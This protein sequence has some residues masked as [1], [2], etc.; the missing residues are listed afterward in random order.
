MS[1]GGKVRCTRCGTQN[2]EFHRFCGM[3]GSSL[4]SPPDAPSAPTEVADAGAF[5][6]ATAP[7]SSSNL[8]GAEAGVS[9]LS[10]TDAHRRRGE[11]DE[12]GSAGS[13]SAGSER[14]ESVASESTG[15]A[16]IGSA[17][18]GS[19]SA[20]SGVSAP[21]VSGPSFLGLDKGGFTASAYRDESSDSGMGSS[22]MGGGEVR[23]SRERYGSNLDY[24]L[25]DE[26]E[27]QRAWGKLMSVVVAL[28]LLGGFGYLRWKQGG[29][30]WLTKDKEK[31]RT[32]VSAADSKPPAGDSTFTTAPANDAASPT[33][34]PG[35]PTADP[36]ASAP[37][38]SVPSADAADTAVAP[39]TAAATSASSPSATTNDPQPALPAARPPSSDV[40]SSTAASSSP[41]ALPSRTM[42]ASGKPTPSVSK[43]N[44]T[45]K[46]APVAADP[47]P[48]AERYIYGSG[49]AQ[50]CDRGLN[51]LKPAASHANVKAMVTLAT[52]YS[53]GTCTPRD[54]PTA[55]RWFAM[56]LHQQPDDKTLQS[57]LQ[58]IWAKMTQPERQLAIKL[59]Q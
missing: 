23:D 11:F 54:L 47:T 4:P 41:E 39:N 58:N 25:D 18:V 33:P 56:A 31:E 15:S 42:P 19:V 48:E 26:E 12:P 36:S 34:A 9:R 44:E 37:A 29:F 22:E 32:A 57:D 50:D 49:V 43:P 46:P 40:A 59:S 24:L 53:S 35:A 5:A 52:L 6:A 13:K 20:D 7:P 1:P 51:L 17:R 10:L 21:L 2:D 8:R 45:P 16:K 14:S 30:D 38:G 27:P 28:A 55:Y 3:C